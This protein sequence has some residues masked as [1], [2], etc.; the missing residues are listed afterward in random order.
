MQ[1]AAPQFSQPLRQIALMLTVV[2]LAGLGG[3]VAFPRVSQVFWENPYLNTGIFAVFLIGVMVY[4]N[5]ND[6]VQLFMK[7]A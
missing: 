6:L 1:K 2:G 5:L 4:T 7:M 3:W